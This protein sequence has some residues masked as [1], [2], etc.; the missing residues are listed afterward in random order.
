MTRLV[1][2]P[3]GPLARALHD[4]EPA[5]RMGA[6]VTAILE[7]RP[8]ELAILATAG[9]HAPVGATTTE[10]LADAVGRGVG[11]A[12]V[13]AV[14]GLHGMAITL[15]DASPGLRVRLSCRPAC[16]GPDTFRSTA[17]RSSAMR[18]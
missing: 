11:L 18:A 16:S 12:L 8:D 14:A 15:E 6:A 7:Q 4:A 1:I 5:G 10:D 17:V 9:P 13:A 3:D 2:G